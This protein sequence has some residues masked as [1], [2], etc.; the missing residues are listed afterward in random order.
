MNAAT[1]EVTCKNCGL[2]RS[3]HPNDGAVMRLRRLGFPERGSVVH[4]ARFE[5][6]TPQKIS[7][8]ILDLTSKGASLQ[9]AVDT[10]LGAGT[11]AK[12]AGATYDALR[13]KAV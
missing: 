8:A 12:I 5:W 11:Y 6:P 2:P 1:L 7:V 3:T 13:A 10:V 9:V 4:C